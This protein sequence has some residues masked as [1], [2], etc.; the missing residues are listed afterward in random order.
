MKL[1][2]LLRRY[3]RRYFNWSGFR[4]RDRKRTPDPAPQTSGRYPSSS[5]FVAALVLICVWSVASLSLV[6]RH[7]VPYFQ[8]VAGQTV[9]NYVYSEVPF[10]YEDLTQTRRKREQAASQTPPAY[11][12]DAST[13]ETILQELG[14]VHS[15]VLGRLQ[16]PL[17]SADEQVDSPPPSARVLEMIGL[18]D[19]EHITRLDY[20]LANRAKCHIVPTMVS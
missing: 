17:G 12:L 2:D 13:T 4:F 16:Q 6:Y 19:S 10:E 11:R 18:L 15:V 14:D 8:Y 9:G 3:E 1:L 7:S 5:V 20:V